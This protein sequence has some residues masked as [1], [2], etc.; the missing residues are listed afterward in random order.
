MREDSIAITPYGLEVI[1][2][3]LHLPLSHQRVIPV[4]ADCRLRHL[5]SARSGLHIAQSLSFRNRS[6]YPF[7][8][9]ESRL[10]VA[11][12]LSR[13]QRYSIPFSVTWHP[14]AVVCA[15]VCVS[16]VNARN[17]CRPI[18]PG[19]ASSLTH[20]RQLPSMNLAEGEFPDNLNDYRR[21]HVSGHYEITFDRD[22]Q[23]LWYK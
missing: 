2:R 6:I 17:A 13:L 12:S 16:A 8:P 1:P 14:V 10:A 3:R 20:R 19:F 11:H 5:A 9:P 23:C 4:S 7:A 21:V 22:E 15:I 18:I